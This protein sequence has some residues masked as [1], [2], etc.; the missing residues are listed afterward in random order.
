MLWFRDISIKAKV[1]IVIL[2]GVLVALVSVIG[3]LFLFQMQSFRTSFSNDLSALAA[4]VAETCAGSVIFVNPA[5][6][7]QTLHALSAK[8]EITGA[9]VR[10]YE[11]PD[12]MLGY[13]GSFG[14][15]ALDQ[16]PHERTIHRGERDWIVTQPIRS[17]GVQTGMLYLCVN[18][19]RESDKVFRNYMLVLLP[20]AC[21]SIVMVLIFTSRLQVAIT[22]PMGRLAEAA[23]KVA[24]EKDY[25]QRV[26]KF[27]NDELGQ[28]TDAFNNMLEEIRR[29]N[30]ELFQQVQALQ[31]SEARFRG[32]VENLGE[33]LLLLGKVG[34]VLLCN[35]PFIRIFGWNPTGFTFQ[36][37]IQ[38]IC[39]EADREKLVDL[40]ESA[41]RGISKELAELLLQKEDGVSLW[42]DIQSCAMQN[43]EGQ[44]QGAIIVISDVSERKVAAESLAELNKQLMLSS[45]LAG[46][47]EVATGVI[48]NVG[49]VLNSVNVSASV[50]G[51]RLRESKVSFLTK[52]AELLLRQGEGVG[53]WMETEAGKRFPDYLA[54]LSE[55]F[56]KDHA[57]LAKEIQLL[58][59]NIEHI[60]SI[61]TVQQNY[62]KSSGIIEDVDAADLM[63]DAV[64]VIAAGGGFR[65]IELK[66]DYQPTPALRVDKHKA[67]QILV[68]ILRNAVQALPDQ[69]QPEISLSIYIPAPARVMMR[70]TDNGVGIPEE[71]L[72]RIFSHG[73]TT[74]RDGHG[75]GL[76]TGAI[77]AQ[78]MRGSLIATSDGV[79]KGAVF[80]L[81]LPTGGLSS[82]RGQ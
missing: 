38:K 57:V 6:C 10:A 27:G 76:H 45:R 71:N 58:G 51:D 13:Y 69:P 79:G 42:V 61:V 1:V 39:A 55:N 36:D 54:G 78:E 4:I 15:H 35:P 31:V 17:D 29:Q 46:M 43:S 30:L 24:L 23:R 21:A 75:F 26:K 16:L 12:K 53:R 66:R 8:P 77:A 74:K 40:W 32:V 18:Y 20:I 49:N 19:G 81:E 47:A 41:R 5:E 37:V 9:C 22:G 80:L 56:A 11:L 59:E 73:F 14:G 70:V 64:K 82:E 52:A 34:E 65:G 33:G 63:E 25:D 7:E 2:T 28:L 67:L 60:K 62:A 50:A 44:M 72:T 68:N 48:H 3:C